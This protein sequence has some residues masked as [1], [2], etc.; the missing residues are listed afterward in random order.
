MKDIA[1]L[2]AVTGILVRDGLASYDKLQ[3]VA[4]FQLCVAHVMRELQAVTDSHQHQVGQW[5]WAE[6]AKDAFSALIHDP[7][8]LTTNR[9]LII[10]AITCA[11]S[12]PSPPATLALQHAAL[13][14]RLRK[15]LDTDYLRFATNP[16]VPPTNNPAEG[17]IRMVK[18]KTKVSGAMRTTTGA[19]A[20]LA[21]RSY[22]STALKNHIGYL[23]ALTT[24][25]TGQPWLPT[26]P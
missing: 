24:I 11:A 4:G 14:R 5:C 13:R 2:P 21:V 20:F 7:G 10:S 17:E 9:H 8:T 26:Q 3:H 23:D 25:F 16:G 12:D 18:V 15:R 22:L 19:N 1:I 6:Q